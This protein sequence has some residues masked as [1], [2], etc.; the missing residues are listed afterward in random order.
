MK[1]FRKKKEILET[2]VSP[3][4][5]V[6]HHRIFLTLST[7]SYHS[8]FIYKAKENLIRIKSNVSLNYNYHKIS[9]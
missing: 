7:F 6:A 3:I 2:Q 1:Q 9:V 4:S 8:D 5:Y